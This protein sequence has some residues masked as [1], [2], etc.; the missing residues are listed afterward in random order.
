TPT[1]LGTTTIGTW[2]LYF[3]GSDVKLTDTSE[4][5]DGFAVKDNGDIYLSTVG[6]FSVGT[7]IT[8]TGSDVFVFH[9]TSLGANTAGSFDSAL[10]FKGSAQGLGSNL[11]SDFSFLKVVN[12]FGASE[13]ALPGESPD[14]EP[15]PLGGPGAAETGPTST[16]AP[17]ATF[18]PP[19]TSADLSAA[20]E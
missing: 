7:N 14:G 9:P 19:S 11:L 8:G 15:A 2:S 3:D 17:A 4:D 12:L 1:M 6:N 20:A 16:S 5:V 13:P 10:Y 18:T